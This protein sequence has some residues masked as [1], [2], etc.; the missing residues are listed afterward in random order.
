MSC[1]QVP[2]RLSIYCRFYICF[3]LLSSIQ[4]AQY[5][6]SEMPAMYDDDQKSY[7]YGLVLVEIHICIGQL[8]MFF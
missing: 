5:T 2:Q 8:N 3:S 1:L 7:L 4:Y 6:V